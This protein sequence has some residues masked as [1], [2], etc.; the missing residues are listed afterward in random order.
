MAQ[1][2][3]GSD[4]DI[5]ERSLSNYSAANPQEK[6][7][8]HFDRDNY[9]IGDTVWF[10]VYLVNQI[11]N[12]LS[13]LSKIVHIDITSPN[14][15]TRKMLLPVSF[16]VST[17]QVTLS[18][19]LYQ[20][21]KYRLK[22]YT[23]LMGN[24]GADYFFNHSFYVSGNSANAVADSKNK[25]KVMV[26]PNETDTTVRIPQLSLKFFPEGG[27]L[28]T[29]IRSKVAFKSIG[30]DG[31]GKTIKGHIENEKGEQVSAFSTLHAG[32]GIF[33]LKP[34]IGSTYTAVITDGPYTGRSFVLPNAQNGYGISVNPKGSDSLQ[35][36]ISRSAGMAADK[37]VRL[38]MQANGVV[39]QALVLPF[40]SSSVTF[41]I[42]SSQMAQGINQL[43]FFSAANIPFAERLVFIYKNNASNDT[44]S[45]DKTVYG[46]RDKVKINFRTS[47]EKGEGIVGSYSAAV[48]K[49]DRL[50]LREEKQLSIYGN[51]LLTSD[52][53]GYIEDPNFYF[54]D[55]HS[56]KTPEL[57]VL[58]LT[59]G[60]RRFK[61]TAVLSQTPKP[62]RYKTEEGL[63]IGGR[64]T[65]RGGEPVAGAKINLL[66]A[67]EMLFLDT[68]AD[69]EGRFA[70]KDLELGDSVDVI[71]RARGLKES[72]NVMIVLDKME[73]V[74]FTTVKESDAID[75]PE[76]SP[77]EIAQPSQPQ[78]TGKI[79]QGTTLKTVQIKGKRIPEIKGSVYPFAMVPPDITIEPDV[80]QKLT[81]I[82][83]YMRSRFPGIEVVGNRLY[84]IRG[85][86]KG[87][88]VILL[89]GN[90]IDD[91]AGIN[92]RALTG[93]QIVKAG[94]VAR[95]NASALMIKSD[96]PSGKNE[97][98][99]N[100]G[101]VFLTMGQIPDKFLKV[102]R[103]SGFLQHA[104]KGYTYSREFYAP[105]YDQQ[106]EMPKADFRNTLFWKPN[107]I[108]GED[109]KAE[110]DFYTSDETGKYQVTLE[111]IGTN[112]QLC[113]KISYFVVN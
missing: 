38:L 109:G 24:A 19:S 35:I 63:T 99:P 86:G 91:L 14:G 33:A 97:P 17:G 50:A 34:L 53:K 36:S 6:V 104:M 58:M 106:R 85:G 41:V 68:I 7:H 81:S 64:V 27:N 2:P 67:K 20:A 73:D 100:F 26:K 57:D 77:Q 74:E 13:A 94:I 49:T 75:E 66:V 65:T 72:N 90:Q 32:M 30:S 48:V 95:N 31:L 88:M 111:G 76:Y 22:A 87:R 71:L 37:S 5:V 101:I 59:Q 47:N 93:V 84:G 23:R 10:K 39:Q 60:W 56:I 69:A 4:L 18:D 61:W 52:L 11:G 40:N 70:F 108:T 107:I 80:L 25:P 44:L 103:P 79:V 9:S 89:N 62:F 46:V 54:L 78:G 42:P 28:T 8:I 83:D 113:R 12:T 43:T 21:G 29:G 16:G 98:H 1:Q 110:F 3:S 102:N 51:L 92:P 105:T 45:S 96:D 15:T 55:Q 112:G 82:E